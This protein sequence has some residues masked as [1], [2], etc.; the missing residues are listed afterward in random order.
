MA[1]VSR[2]HSITHGFHDTSSAKILPSIPLFSLPLLPCST[3]VYST[4]ATQDQLAWS[5]P[6]EASS[7]KHR[8]C[9]FSFASLES[10]FASSRASRFV[11]SWNKVTEVS[12]TTSNRLKQTSHI[13]QFSSISRRT[14][15]IVT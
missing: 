15:C 9:S 8:R 2:I 3:T 4:L 6:S 12:Y 13:K 7:T 1:R 10:E 11:F 14:P 5:V